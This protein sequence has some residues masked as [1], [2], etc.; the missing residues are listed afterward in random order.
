MNDH[1]HITGIESAHVRV[2]SES[3][4]GAVP[5]QAIGLALC[6]LCIAALAC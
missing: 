2:V 4:W 1:V 6:A 3:M 5:T